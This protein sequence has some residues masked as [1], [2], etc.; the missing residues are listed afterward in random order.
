MA[1]SVNNSMKN[2]MK[3]SISV[4]DSMKKAMNDTMKDEMQDAMKDASS[5]SQNTMSM[6]ITQKFGGPINAFAYLLFVL[7]YFP[8]VSVLATIA[9]ELNVFWAMFSVVW[10]TSLAYMLSVLFYQS[11]T[12][13]EHPERSCSWLITMV[14]ALFLSFKV[15]RRWVQYYI[16]KD[17]DKRPPL[18]TQILISTH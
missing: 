15:M 9:R 1:N 16:S 17:K 10:T 3:N 2:S 18:P 12:F 8:C 7:L 11:A 5:L 13:F 4:N 6:Q 14:I